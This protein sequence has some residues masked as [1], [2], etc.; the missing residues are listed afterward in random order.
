VGRA[1]QWVGH[2]ELDEARGAQWLERQPKAL[3]GRIE[4]RDLAIEAA[5]GFDRI[6]MAHGLATRVEH[7]NRGRGTRI[8]R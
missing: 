3:D 6:E 8:S 1:G 5:V 4:P 7:C 2:G